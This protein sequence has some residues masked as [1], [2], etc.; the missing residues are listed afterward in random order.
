MSYDWE[1]GEEMNE[2]DISGLREFFDEDDEDRE[3]NPPEGVLT[4]R[5]ASAE[6][7]RA[8]PSDRQLVWYRYN[9]AGHLTQ[10]TEPDGSVLDPDD[11]LVALPRYMKSISRERYG[12]EWAMNIEY[13]LWDEVLLL[14]DP[15]SV[16]FTRAANT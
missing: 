2:Q 10:I 14:D 16:V 4:A 6:E 13:I 8:F 3:Q 12:E 15:T 7:A 11:P 9:A 1:V 5:L